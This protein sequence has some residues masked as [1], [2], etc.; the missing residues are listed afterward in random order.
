MNPSMA[1][2]DVE[3]ISPS[4]LNPR[5]HQDP[6]KLKELAASIKQ[7]GVIE[8]IIIRPIKGKTPYEIVAGERPPPN[9]YNEI[10]SKVRRVVMEHFGVN[11]A[12]EFAITEDYLKL[13]TKAEILAFGKKF[14][15]FPEIK[16]LMKVKNSGFASCPE[17]LKKGELIDLI[18][19]G[20]ADLVGKVPDEILKVKK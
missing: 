5:K 10:D 8:P 4:P 3:L 11:L 15:I 13:K 16:K 7:K 1:M 17:K 14:K 9:D 12:K 19:K 18:L 6:A 2:I 20:G